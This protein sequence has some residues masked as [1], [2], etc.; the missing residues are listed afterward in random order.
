MTKPTDRRMIR[1][2]TGA[3]GGGPCQGRWIPRP[4]VPVQPVVS[5]DTW[6]GDRQAIPSL[7]DL[8]PRTFTTA[9]RMAIAL[10]LQLE[11]IGAGDEVLVP[12]YHCSAMIEPVVAM[13]ATPVFYKIGADLAAD[14]SDLSAKCTAR[15]RA[16]LAT[17]YFGFP[18]D[19]PNLRAWADPRNVL[20]IEDCAHSL[21]GTLDGRALGTFG[22]YAIA[23]LPKFLPVWDG[24]CLVGRRSK[25]TMSS[26]G[27]GSQIRSILDP[28][29]D[30]V[31][32][33]RLRPL[34]V[35]TASMEFA[36]IAARAFRAPGTTPSNPAH[37]RSGGGDEF[38]R[39]WIKVEATMAARATVRVAAR[40]HVA[41]RRIA[42][43][44]RYLGAFSGMMECRPLFPTLPAGVVPFMFPLWVDRLSQVF[45]RLEDRAVP[46]QRFGQFLW[47]GVGEEVC[48]NSHRLSRHVVQLPC[49][50]ELTDKE[51]DWVVDQVRECIEAAGQ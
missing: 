39:A 13:G 2:M 4:F 3:D 35:L 5:L 10:A 26:Q 15:T 20:V 24:G 38:D 33:R 44:G 11:G 31:I 27:F 45:P 48:A 36:R 49:H 34:R 14:L 25:V 30:A 19:W 46:M 23:S 32:H 28:I 37:L 8:E 1:S 42:A 40:G 29:E 51:I 9:G 6:F 17:N 43:Y 50:Q 41:S 12:A 21:F 22:D 47:A 7:L 18:Q 16:L